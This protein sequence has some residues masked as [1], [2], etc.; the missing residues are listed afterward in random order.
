MFWVAVPLA[1][2]PRA[3]VRNWR[4]LLPG[5]RWKSSKKKWWSKVKSK[6][7]RSTPAPSPWF[8]KC[9]RQREVSGVAMQIYFYTFPRSRIMHALIHTTKNVHA[10][11]YIR[12]PT[13]L[14]PNHL[15]A[16]SHMCSDGHLPRLLDAAAHLCVSVV[17]LSTH[18]TSINQST[19]Q[20]INQSTNQSI[21]VIWRK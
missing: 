10:H 19:N 1:I 12:G 7:R 11:E 14:A 15:S 5:F 16:H 17:L 4:V 3:S 18:I 20:I 9:S 13:L 8:P 6:R 2:L 21:Y